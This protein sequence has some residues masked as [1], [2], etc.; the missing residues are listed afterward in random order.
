MWERRKPGR[1][2]LLQMWWVGESSFGLVYHILHLGGGNPHPAHLSGGWGG[3][4]S[5]KAEAGAV[6]LRHAGSSAIASGAISSPLPDLERG[7]REDKRPHFLPSPSLPWRPLS[8]PPGV[9]SPG[10]PPGRLWLAVLGGGRS[11]GAPLPPPG[12]TEGAGRSR[13]HGSAGPACSARPGWGRRG[14]APWRSPFFFPER[15]V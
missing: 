7:R 10:R 11:L 5:R 14:P 1:R 9:S 6:G 2:A 15:G 13:R 12:G 4:A 3:R 8:W